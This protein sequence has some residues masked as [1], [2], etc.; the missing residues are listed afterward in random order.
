MREE[1]AGGLDLAQRLA[2]RRVVEG[3]GQLRDARLG[4]GLV[5]V[6]L[7]CFIQARAPAPRRVEDRDEYFPRAAPGR[8]SRPR[9]RQ[10]GGN[11]QQRRLV[12]RASA[13]ASASAIWAL[14]RSTSGAASALA[15]AA[16]QGVDERRPRVFSGTAPPR[17][18]VVAREA[19]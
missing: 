9:G 19:R 11:E 8:L 18:L 3:D 14:P 1:R 13:Q 10:V 2:Q 7:P 17:E 12:R 4:V 15:L 16:L 6:L 5:E